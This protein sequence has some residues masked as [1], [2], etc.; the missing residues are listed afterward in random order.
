MNNKALVVFLATLAGVLFGFHI[1]V[2]FASMFTAS[3]AWLLAWGV[4]SAS[5]FGYW[6]YSDAYKFD[7]SFNLPPSEGWSKLGFR[8]LATWFGS[9]MICSA[10]LQALTVLG[11]ANLI[12]ASVLGTALAALLAVIQPAAER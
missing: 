9:A 8:F 5:G 7:K 1:A 4:A 3:F 2:L 11:P 6:A 10:A 12:L